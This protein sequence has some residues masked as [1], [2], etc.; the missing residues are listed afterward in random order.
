MKPIFGDLE[1]KKRMAADAKA[2]RA[3]E[4]KVR[5]AISGIRAFLGSRT[6][7][8]GASKAAHRCQVKDCDKLPWEH[9]DGDWQCQPLTYLWCGQLRHH[10]DKALSQA[11]RRVLAEGKA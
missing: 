1:A 8:E 6:A 5:A 2:S 3:D 10:G 7:D 9:A 11:M 4:I